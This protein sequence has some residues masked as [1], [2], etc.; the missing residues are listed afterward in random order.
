MVPRGLESFSKSGN[1]KKYSQDSKIAKKV[2]SEKD[3]PTS[4]NCLPRRQPFTGEFFPEEAARTWL[5]SLFQ[6]L[7]QWDWVG[8]AG[9]YALDRRF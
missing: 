9:G 1:S 5:E 6:V 7:Q 4:P 8:F 2:I 3:E